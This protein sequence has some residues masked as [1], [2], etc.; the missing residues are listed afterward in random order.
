MKLAKKCTGLLAVFLVFSILLTAC[1]QGRKEESS[2]QNTTT[3]SGSSA[4]TGTGTGD[5]IGS[6]TD[7]WGET[8]DTTV[9][10]GAGDTERTDGTT[11]G[12]DPTTGK[13]TQ[14]QATR[15]S[16]TAVEATGTNRKIV[17]NTGKV[18]N[19]DFLGI[20][21]NVMPMLLM[22]YNLSRGF[23]EAWWELEAK[24]IRS[25]K[26]TVMRVW[27][28]I[29]WFEEQKGVYNFNSEKMQ[30]FYRYM[31]LFQ[32]NDID[33]ELNFS[34]KNG[35]KIQSW[36][37][38]PGV[39]TA[40]S[41]PM[42]LN[43]Y[44][45][46]CSALLKH[47]L[48]VKKYTNLKYLTYYNEPEANDFECYG[49][50]ME[51]YIAMSKKV[52]D[53]LVK[54]GL[55]NSV[56]IWGGEESSRSAYWNPALFDASP[57]GIFDA[58]SNHT[59]VTDFDQL[60]LV[61]NSLRMHIPDSMPLYITEFGWADR[62][63]YGWNQSYTNY[64]IAIANNGL[65]GGLVWQLNGVFLEDPREGQALTAGNNPLW[66]LESLGPT[67]RKANHSFY[68]TA[69]MSRYIPKHSQ[70]V[71]TDVTGSNDI[72][73]AAFKSGSDFTVI[74]ESNDSAARKLTLQFSKA[75]NKT[76]YKHVYTKNHVPEENAVI[77]RS[78]KAF[79]CG[80]S[81]VDDLPADYCTIVYTTIKPAVQIRLNKVVSDIS[82]GDQVQLSAE[83]IDGTGGVTF[84]IVKTSGADSAK[85]AIT[86]NG[87]YTASA[88]AKPGDTIAVRVASV[89]DPTVYAVAIMCIK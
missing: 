15:P 74:V 88:N 62:A 79:D 24:R 19:N 12:T 59:Y 44:A 1:N 41:A 89:S 22:P 56:K 71:A 32:Q 52:H 54:D 28:Q 9:P 10:G 17:V 4:T 61:Y 70:V 40:E 51:Y 78:V 43:A 34:W 83:V 64:M 66:N 16:S 49:N 3:S 39:R 72:R 31:D 82:A 18:I 30:A 25:M 58:F 35:T 45:R 63:D 85:G 60:N 73:S 68:E 8:T 23:N 55:R 26:M 27:F 33:V 7:T 6:E 57:K 37:N 87:L 80:S 38:L 36:F 50:E 77:P 86:A 29:D 20:G 21:A 42:D 84:L 67:F 48:K 75:I 65:S 2:G 11:S 5:T 13:P 47:L 46:S 53:Q 69:M 81:L 14:P 76:V